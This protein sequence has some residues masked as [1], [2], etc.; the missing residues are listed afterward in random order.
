M[1]NTY[2]TLA[3]RLLCLLVLVWGSTS[4]AAD[5]LDYG[6]HWFGLNNVSQKADP[7]VDNP[8]Y[9]RRKPTIIYV[10]G[11]QNGSTVAGRRETF[12]YKK[13]D[14][15]YGID[16]NGADAW[17]LD[18][19]NIGIFYWNQFADE[20][21]V[22]DAEAKIWSANGPRGMRY[23]L[24]NGSYSTAAGVN[25][26]ASQLMFDSIVEAMQD[27]RG[28]NL[29]IAGHSLGNQMAVAVSDKLATAVAKK[30]ISSRLLPSRVALLDPFYSKGSKSYLNGLWTGEKARE[31]VPVLKN[32]GVLFEYY[33]TS[34]I[35]D[36]WI[37][38]KNE[39]L[40]DMCAYNSVAPWYIPSWGIAEKHIAA[41][42]L[43]FISYSSA[44]P[45]EVTIN[46][47]GRR[48]QT[49]KDALS[50]STSD[51]RLDEMMNSN[52]R[53]VQVEGRYTIT[54]DDDQY[55]RKNK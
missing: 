20:F 49:G 41:P 51:N 37:G 48:K 30:Q 35:T 6:I 47:W 14:P 7:A 54:A 53:W 33:Q 3:Q 16:Y 50:A 2:K 18:G 12:N 17:I 9:D 27:Y 29:R 25:V 19:W 23:K 8:Y 13:N 11:W 38:D 22:K 36:L 26:S 44:P 1:L 55:A 4:L 21:E 34:G 28:S 5:D 24:P 10:H 32:K 40:K 52:Y 45:E 15:V 46:W 31:I 39:G 42:N 43:Y